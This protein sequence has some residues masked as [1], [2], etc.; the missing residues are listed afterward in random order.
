MSDLTDL[1]KTRRS[2]RRYKQKPVP[3]DL[4]RNILETTSYAPSAH[5]AQPWRF[6]VIAE[7]EQKNAIANAMA[8]VWMSEL[9][10]DH[11]PKNMR[12]AT[13]NRSVERF[14]SAPVLI[15]ACMSMEDMDSYSDAERRKDERDLAVQSLGAAVQTLLLAAHSNGL[16]SCWFCAPIFCKTKVQ[17]A[18]G[19]PAEV[20]PQALITLGF[21]DEAPKLP[22]RKPFAEFVY[23]QRWGVTFTTQTT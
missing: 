7:T 22:K 15:L 19:I 13:V 23:Q 9:E 16:G 12:W 1:L 18:L 6:I 11:I 4:I 10:R 14:T 5:N 20:E 21:A 2:I 3:S 8:Q 17:Q